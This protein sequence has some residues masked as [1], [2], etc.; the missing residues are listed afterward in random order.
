[1]KTKWAQISSFLKETL[2]PGVFKVWIAPL[3]GIAEGD[4]AEIY[5]PNAYMAEWIKKRL[6]ESIRAAAAKVLGKD[7]ISVSVVVREKPKNPARPPE[8]AET[9]LS[10]VMPDRAPEQALLPAAPARVETGPW[11]YSFEDFVTGP[12]NSFAFAAARDLG[13]R[14]QVSALFVNSA[15]GLGKTHL[16]QAAG[17]ALSVAG[18]PL[19]VVYL[20]AERFA[21]RFVM[22]MKAKELEDF[23]RELCSADAFIFEDAH[24]LQRKKVMQETL[25]GVVKCLEAKGARII[26]TSSFSPRQMKDMDD[27]LLSHFCSGILANMERPDHETRREILRRKAKSYQVTLPDEVCELVSGK[28]SSDI[29]SL[30]ACLKNMIFKARLLNSGLTIDLAM[31][32]MAQFSETAA[33]LDM[34]NIVRLVCESFGLTRTQLCS[35]SRRKEYV[36]GRN[37]AFYLARKHTD[38]SLE[39]IGCVF[40]RRHST[41]VRSITQVEQELASE[42][43]AGRQIA[44]AVSLI[45][46]KCGL[47]GR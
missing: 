39:E 13:A 38:M 7:D 42:S 1:M 25:L 32:T 15:P 23:K 22:A 18:N 17:Q 21:S 10:R 8:K 41:V 37:T 28:L 4:S 47:D 11:R 34:E 36:Q 46:R 16:A 14:G 3:D 12:S 26:F 45:E 24:F 9:I 5:A 44:R 30:E 40:N 27:E 6:M 19:K 31:E 43:R 20:T 2:E 29:R 35:R 33:P